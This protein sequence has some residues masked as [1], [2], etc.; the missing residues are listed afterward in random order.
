MPLIMTKKLDGQIITVPTAPSTGYTGL[1]N[2]LGLVDNKG[3]EI[4]V[5]AKPVDR[6]DLTWAINYTFSKNWNKVVALTAGLD[7]V[8]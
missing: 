5:D 8:I 1:V 7:N 4:H 6:R 2:N 3:V